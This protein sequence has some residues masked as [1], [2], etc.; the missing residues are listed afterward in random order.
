M[1]KELFET[2]LTTEINELCHQLSV[3]LVP[4]SRIEKVLARIRELTE[5]R[6]RI[7]KAFDGDEDDTDTDK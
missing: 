2:S 3:G 1:G 5:Q 6:D 7:R 4:K